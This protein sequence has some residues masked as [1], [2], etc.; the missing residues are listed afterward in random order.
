M[1]DRIKNERTPF[2]IIPEWVLDSPISDRALRLYAVL[3]RYADEETGRCF[4]ARRTLADRLRCSIDSVDRA[5]GEL[6]EH[7]A[8]EKDAAYTPKGDRTSNTITVRWSRTGAVGSREPA[9]TSSQPSGDGGRTGAAENESQLERDPSNDRADLVLV[10]SEDARAEP[11]ESEF[12]RAWKHYPRKD[13]RK[14]ALRAYQAARRRGVPA[15][16]LRAATEAYAA[17]RAGQDAAFTMLGSTFYG[18]DARFLD[19][20][21]GVLPDL[22]APPATDVDAMAERVAERAAAGLPTGAKYETRQPWE[23]E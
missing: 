8:I 12:N 21:P 19:F 7:G 13:A 16:V 15:E 23:T 10:G 20:V 4:P 11:F 17:K 1:T 3:R 9:A 18:P 2:A 6:I 22:V 5:T 14:R